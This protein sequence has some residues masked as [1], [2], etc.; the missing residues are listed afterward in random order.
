[1][2]IRRIWKETGV[3][4]VAERLVS[5]LTQPP[6]VYPNGD[7]SLA[8][9]WFALDD[10]PPLSELTRNRIA[11]ALPPDAPAWFAEPGN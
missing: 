1:M 3:H 8:V 2:P 4:I 11:W 7:E 10:L 9:G 6:N 5:V